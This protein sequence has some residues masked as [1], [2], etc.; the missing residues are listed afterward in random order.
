MS[1]SELIDCGKGVMSVAATCRLLDV[2]RSSYYEQRARGP[3]QRKLQDAA[4]AVHVR[5]VHERS[6]KRYG[7]P[8]IHKALRARGVHVGR[9]RVAR[10][11]CEHRLVARPKRRFRVTTNSEHSF[12]IAPNLLQRNFTAES[13]DKVWIGDIT[14]VW[15]REGWMYLAVLIDVYS[16]RVVGWAM[17][18]YLSRELA[19]ETLRRA[20]ELRRPAPGLIHHTD[21][22][23][24]YASHD[25][26]ALLR[27]HGL[28]PSMSRRGNCLDNAMAESFFSTLEHE[29]LRDFV[30]DTRTQATSEVAEYIENFYNRERMHSALDYISPMEY[31]LRD[32]MQMAA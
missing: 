7:S 30:F 21:R 23:C 5:D 14:Y 29:L 19:L 13:P 27:E 16:R 8:R 10:L 15:T 9:K 22:G 3:S 4:L 17:R 20:L 18:P 26:Q 24:Q 6:K 31:E 11:M 32:V 1:P 2:P 25:Y 12:P 28:R